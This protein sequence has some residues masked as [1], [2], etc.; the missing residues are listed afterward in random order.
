MANTKALWPSIKLMIE[1]YHKS[2]RGSN[3][4]SVFLLA[5]INNLVYL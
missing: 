1:Y 5:E 4:T 2:D 3:P